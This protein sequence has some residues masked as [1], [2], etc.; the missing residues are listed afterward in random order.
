MYDDFITAIN[1]KKVIKITF[2]SAEKGIITRNCIPFDYGPS[3]RYKD[4]K[5]RYHMYDLDSPDG[6]HNL[7][8][9]PENLNA[10]EI[11]EDFFEPGDYVKWTPNWYVAR[12]WGKY[13]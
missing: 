11:T 13:S 1:D 5:D 6:S 4:G 12:D 3:R 2:D 7:S 10:L 8:I 9:L